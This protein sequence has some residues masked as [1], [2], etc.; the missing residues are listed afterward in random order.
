[1]LS[2][3]GSLANTRFAFNDVSIKTGCRVSTA[4]VWLDGCT[5]LEIREEGV[6]TLL[7]NLHICCVRTQF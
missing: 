4:G 1:M 7:T 3:R 6:G 5:S 2:W